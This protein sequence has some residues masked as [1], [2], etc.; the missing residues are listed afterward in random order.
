VVFQQD[1]GEDTAAAA[2]RIDSFDPDSS[3][4]AVTEPD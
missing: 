1:L 2:A 4:V 3:W